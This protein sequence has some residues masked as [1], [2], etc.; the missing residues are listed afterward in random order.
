MSTRIA[1]NCRPGAAGSGPDPCGQREEVALHEPDPRVGRQTDRVGEQVPLVPADHLSQRLDD[2]Q[3]TYA[4]IRE[5]GTRGVAEAEPAHE[6]LQLGPGDRGQ[7]EVRQLDLGDREQARHQ[8][9]VAELHLVDVDLERR[10]ESPAQADRPMGVSDQSSSSMREARR[11]P[12]SISGS[13]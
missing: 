10:L 7:S 8:E 11:G 5:R 6:H 1:E 12:S 4:C 2:D 3:R 13:G 9:L